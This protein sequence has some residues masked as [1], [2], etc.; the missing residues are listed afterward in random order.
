MRR[1]GPA[2][3]RCAVGARCSPSRLLLRDWQTARACPSGR[4]SA[5]SG[6]RVMRKPACREKQGLCCRVIAGNWLKYHSVPAALRPPLG[7]SRRRMATWAAG[8]LQAADRPDPAFTTA[9]PV[10]IDRQQAGKRA[11]AAAPRM[12][13]LPPVSENRG[14]YA[15]AAVTAAV[16]GGLLLR[17]ALRC[18]AAARCCRAA[19]SAMRAQAARCQS[20]PNAR[21][22][23]PSRTA[24]ITPTWVEPTLQADQAPGGPLHPGH[25]AQGRLRR[26]HSRRGSASCG[27]GCR[28]Y[29]R[30]RRRRLPAAARLPRLFALTRHAPPSAPVPQA[31]PAPWPPTTWPRA[32]PAW[33]CWTRCGPL[34]AAGQVLPVHARSREP[35]SPGLPAGGSVH[36][37]QARCRRRCFTAFMLAKCAH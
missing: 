30:R 23:A 9:L 26:D 17:R 8:C 35:S 28:R 11:P 15:A 14:L 5:S 3:R 22:H 20:I 24:A 12:V 25:A 34:F 27:R 1:R 19:P 7:P 36:A 29:R 21:S 6:L 4:R 2:G 13:Q 10:G 33:P 31:P 16:G 18:G 37:L 32:A